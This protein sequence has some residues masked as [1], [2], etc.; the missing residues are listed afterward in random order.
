MKFKKNIT[1]FHVIAMAEDLNSSKHSPLVYPG[2]A[3][4]SKR[5]IRVFHG[6]NPI[7]KIPSLL[8]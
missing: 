5:L 3:D 4:G 7:I 2:L 8:I 6:L 1:W